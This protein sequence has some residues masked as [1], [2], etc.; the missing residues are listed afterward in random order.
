MEDKTRRELT[1]EAIGV[2][3]MKEDKVQKEVVEVI[4]KEG[5]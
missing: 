3:T 5:C 2:A 4:Q 1:M